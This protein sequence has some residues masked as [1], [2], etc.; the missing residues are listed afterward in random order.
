MCLKLHD[1]KLHLPLFQETQMRS[2]VSGLT[3]RRIG[4][5][6]HCEAPMRE[7]GCWCGGSGCTATDMAGGVDCN[8]CMAHISAV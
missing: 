1:G 7:G 5:P 2:S 3:G 8:A 4:P 6:D